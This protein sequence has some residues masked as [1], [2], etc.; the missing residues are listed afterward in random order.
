MVRDAFGE[1]AAP[2][3]APATYA[4]GEALKKES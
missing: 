4:V 2:S 1:T 3:L